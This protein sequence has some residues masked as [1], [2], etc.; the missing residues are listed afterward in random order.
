MPR[1]HEEMTSRVPLIVLAH[2]QA[3]GLDPAAL[4]AKHGLPTD[5]DWRAAGK[6]EVTLP[7]GTLRGLVDDVATQL[8]DAHFGLTLA[9]SLQ[10][11]TYGVAE[12][13]IRSTA[14]AR[15]ACEN[16]V[17]FN[18]LMAPDQLFRFDDSGD[19]AVVEHG[20]PGF[21]QG[22]SRHH[23]EYTTFLLAHRLQGMVEGC[24]LLRVW[25][26]NPRPADVSA[27]VTEFGTSRLAFDQPMNGFSFD[28]ALLDRPI[29]TQ[30]AA[31]YAFLEE[32]ALAAL[33]SRPR[34]DDLVERLRACIRD[35]LKQGEPHIERLATR[36]A[37]SG[38][39]L[40]RRLSELGT[41][42]QV[43]LDD[44]RFDLARA[45]L[46]EAR[47][48]I[49]QIA[50]LLGYSELRAFDRAFKRW[51]NATPREWREQHASKG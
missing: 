35:A 29:K 40:Q 19:E 33:A 31:L 39:T 23:H 21:P 27:L 12:F 11:G 5:L 38:R 43:V 30:D 2:A 4:I 34:A 18:A 24:T 25:F 9:R 14:T 22:M 7:M 3:R 41:T 48:D 16:L 20:V 44:V 32:H 8:G 13:L 6:L 37:L 26:A 42:F 36:L 1:S 10:H 47:L 49:T 46:R 17:R 15:G 45:Y 50:Y 51:A 28:K